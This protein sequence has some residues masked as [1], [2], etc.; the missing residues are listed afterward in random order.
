MVCTACRCEQWYST[1]QRASRT[2]VTMALSSAM[3]PS[4]AA[5]GH[6]GSRGLAPTARVQYAATGSTPSRS[7]L[8]FFTDDGHLLACSTA[9]H[10][11]A[12]IAW[13]AAATVCQKYCLCPLQRW[14][15]RTRRVVESVSCGTQLW[16]RRYA[17]CGV[18]CRATAAEGLVA[19]FRWTLPPPRRS[20]PLSWRCVCRSLPIMRGHGCGDRIAT[21]PTKRLSRSKVRPAAT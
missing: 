17:R 3:R 4:P 7:L 12:P 10:S 19:G 16:M 8:L 20:T 18:L 11:C 13:H 5:C 14:P 21:T 9:A 15:V 6:T 2:T 1:A